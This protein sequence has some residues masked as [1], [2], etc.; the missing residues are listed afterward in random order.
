MRSEVQIHLMVPI[1]ERPTLRAGRPTLRAGRPTL[2]EPFANQFEVLVHATTSA[3]P[4]L[5]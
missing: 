4:N 3:C 1:A 2:R 5:T